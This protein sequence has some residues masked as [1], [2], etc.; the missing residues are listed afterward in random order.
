M[1]GYIGEIRL[2]PYTFTPSGW[3]AC[4]GQR[5]PINQYQVLFSVIGLTYGGDGVQYFNL[6]DLRG[7]AA[8][9][10]GQ[11]QGLSNYPMGQTFGMNTVGLSANQLPP[12]SHGVQLEKETS[13]TN[14]PLGNYL[15]ALMQGTTAKPV[16]WEGTAADSGMAMNAVSPAGGATPHEN[17]QPY[18]A[19][20]FCICEEG[21][22]PVPD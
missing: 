5:L 20:R 11:G 1:D 10:S 12:H 6:P 15:G 2:M 9:Q 19:L 21:E 8:V 14:A 17:R 3:L 18:L 13:D 22:Y 16:Y 4:E 7:L